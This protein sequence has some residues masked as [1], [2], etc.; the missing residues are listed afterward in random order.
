M[1]SIEAR[2]QY[3][4]LFICDRVQPHP[5]LSGERGIRVIGDVVCLDGFESD[6]TKGK[7]PSPLVARS[8]WCNRV[9]YVPPRLS[10]QNTYLEVPILAIFS[11]IE[12]KGVCSRYSPRDPPS[13]TFSS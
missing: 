3:G 1:S 8:V 2:I 7:A 12:P 9:S 6:W 5:F 13:G 4:A 11:N 10:E